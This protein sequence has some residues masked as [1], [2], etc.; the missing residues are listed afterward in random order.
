[1]FTPF[2]VNSNYNIAWNSAFGNDICCMHMSVWIQR[3]KLAVG[4]ML[5]RI[6]FLV[7]KFCTL[8]K[9]FDFSVN[10]QNFPEQLLLY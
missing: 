7:T 8:M 9:Q 1:M 6:S 2:V 10:L 4:S 5:G 3:K